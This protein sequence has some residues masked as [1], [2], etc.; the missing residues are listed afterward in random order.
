MALPLLR[1]VVL[2]VL[3]LASRPTQ[4]Q[5]LFSSN[6]K[7][8]S[9]ARVVIVQDP[10]ATQSL[11]PVP[12]IIQGLV[13]RAIISLT[14]K[15]T[16]SA[17]WMS[18]VST[19]DTI[20]IK[21]FSTPGPNSGTRLPVVVAV[22]QDLLAAGIP[23]GHIIVWDRRAIDL[24]LAGFF[25]LQK[26]F[27]IRVQGS[28]D[29]GY[30]NKVFYE[31]AL[32]GNLS[33]TDM[34]FGKK[35][36]DIGRKSYVSKLVTKEMTKI[37]NITPLMHHNLAG[38][39][40]NLYNL[41]FGSVDNIVRFETDA[42]TLARSLP[43]IYALPI[44]GDRVVLNI[45]DALI[46]QY[47]GEQKGLLHYSSVLNQLRFSRDPVALDVLS[48]F[49]INRQRLLAGVPVLKTNLELYANASLLEIGVSD[50]RH[51]QVDKL[52]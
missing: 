21:V 17:A 4:A 7:R 28:M 44:L 11:Q 46:C 2:G 12:E 50:M 45:V 37:I 32:L 22:V 23:P 38:A 26:R 51:I 40:G 43:E 25:D 16:A 15:S 29:E 6:E 52:P 5:K 49:E 13:D 20:G 34:E 36:L 10:A 27:G 30:D 19:Q 42:E 31:T 1:L 47:E 8:V 24:R 41:A 35:G 33:W 39:S 3:V 9:T 18:L 48:I 14:A